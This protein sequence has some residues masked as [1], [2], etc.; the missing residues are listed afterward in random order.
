MV[1]TPQGHKLVLAKKLLISIPPKLSNF[2][3]FDL[4]TTERG[5]FSQFSDAG[6]YTGLLRNTGIPDDINV[7]NI[8]ADTPY[9]LP[10][11]DPTP[12]H[13]LLQQ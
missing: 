2:K 13:T 3:G 6:Y 1:K 7:N 12:V 10:A 11:G 8:G 9:N 4:S 5:L